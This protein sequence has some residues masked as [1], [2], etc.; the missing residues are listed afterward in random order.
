MERVPVPAYRTLTRA[1]VP[2]RRPPHPSTRLSPIV[3]GWPG[4]LR[5]TCLFLP[6]RSAPMSGTISLDARCAQTTKTIMVDRLL[7]RAEFVDGQ[8]VPAA[9]LLERKQATANRG[10]YLGFPMRHPAFCSLWRQ[11][12]DRQRRTVRPDD[13]VAS[14][15]MRLSHGRRYRPIQT[16]SD[17][18]RGWICDE[19]FDILCPF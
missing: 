11:I 17:D 16:R 6:P 7:P 13:V 18:T 4:G 9:R 10:N 5:A 1:A 8:R 14:W 3:R 12:G 19:R 15:A 2:S